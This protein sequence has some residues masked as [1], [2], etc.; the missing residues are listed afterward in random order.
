ML[1]A[2]LYFS[3]NRLPFAANLFAS[4]IVLGTGSPM[5]SMKNLK[6][7]EDNGAVSFIPFKSNAQADRGTDVWSGMF[8]FL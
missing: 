7:T 6:A 5:R 3:S 1:F 8:Y 4:A 2:T